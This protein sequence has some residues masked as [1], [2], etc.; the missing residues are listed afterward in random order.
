[1]GDESAREY[2]DIVSKTFASEDDAFEFYNSYAHEKGFSVRK[3]YVEWDEANQKIILRKLVCSRQEHYER[4]L[5]TRRLNEAVLDIVALQSVPFTEV[6]ASSLEKHAARVF[7]PAMFVLVRY[8]TDAV[9]NCTLSGE[10]LDTD[11]LTT[12]V[13]A[14]KHR[15]EK[16]QVEYEKKEGSS[17]R[18]SC[19]CRKLECLGTPCSHIFYILGL[20]EVK[21]L[22]SCCVPTRWTM[23]AKATCP[24]TRK[25]CMYDYSASLRR[26]H[27]LRN[28]SH[29]KCF[30]VAHSVE[31]YEHLKMVLN[32]QDDRKESSSGHKE[33]MRYGPVLPQTARLDS[34]ELEK[35][36]DP[37]HVQGR[38]APKKRLKKKRKRSNSKG[39]YCRLEGHNRRKCAKWIEKKAY[40]SR[41][42]KLDKGN[43]A[44]NDIQVISNPNDASKKEESLPNDASKK[45]ISP[46]RPIG[47]QKRK[48]GR[49]R[50]IETLKPTNPV[51]DQYK[52]AT[53]AVTGLAEGRARRKSNPR[54]QQILW[55]IAKVVT[56]KNATIAN[57]EDDY[58][59]EE[60][61]P[62][63]TKGQTRE[64]TFKVYRLLVNLDLSSNSLTG[65]I[66]EEI[67]FLIR[68]TNLNLSSN[69]L[70]G[71]IPNQ[72][73]DLKQLE[74]LD[75][76]Y[77]ELTGEIPSGL[78]DLT[79]LSYLNLSYNNLS[80]A[81][82]S[83]PQ[84]QTLDS[85]IDIYIGN[86]GLCGYPLSKNCST[87]TT[88]A[89]QSVGHEDADHVA[90]LYLG[91]CIGFVVGLWT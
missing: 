74:S 18:I 78:S 31:A 2:Y 28:L 11:D 34:G 24:G 49:P 70:I 22:P 60:S 50:K 26:Y 61:I 84:L 79:S 29:A 68:L 1:M 30:S 36:L 43:A 23:S 12:F 7:T 80:G 35:V 6:D 45:E 10:I 58:V 53:D 85:Q 54:P 19:S 41:M 32:V 75:L 86:L 40:K 44:D 27:E 59:F 88:G 4:C 52:L 21:R 72:I 16:F 81:I 55:N 69:Q 13:V 33:C 73:G 63:I 47:S 42:A 51:K 67:S 48:R 66:P 76:S 83:G 20:L 65:Q 77:N 57:L 71:K 25:S 87:S 5:S 9:R 14:K 15:G 37:M 3:S 89:G 56:R 90:P 39:G 17:E 91:M 38:G 62:V 8:S 46:P 64:Y 82:P